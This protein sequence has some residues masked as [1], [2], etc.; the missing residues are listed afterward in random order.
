MKSRWLTTGLMGC[1]I[2]LLTLG[3]YAVYRHE[4]MRL[5]AQTEDSHASHDPA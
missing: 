3:G 5:R 4:A 2:L 1:S